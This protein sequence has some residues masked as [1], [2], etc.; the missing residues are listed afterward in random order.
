MCLDSIEG[1]TL[2]SVSL[3][4]IGELYSESLILSRKKEEEIG[5]VFPEMFDVSALSRIL[6]RLSI[7]LEYLRTVRKNDFYSFVEQ[8]QFSVD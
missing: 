7:R 4:C 1:T 2:F 6:K 5:Y 8:Y 3:N